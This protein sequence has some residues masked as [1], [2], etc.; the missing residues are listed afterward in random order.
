MSLICGN[1]QIHLLLLTYLKLLL[2]LFDLHNSQ[3]TFLVQNIQL[4]LLNLFSVSNVLQSP[5]DLLV[6]VIL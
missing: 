5:R 2:Q 1:E 3:V 4:V 6:L